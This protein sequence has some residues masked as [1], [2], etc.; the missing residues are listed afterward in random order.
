MRFFLRVSDLFMRW[1]APVTPEFLVCGLVPFFSFW[2]FFMAHFYLMP[3]LL[4][5]RS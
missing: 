1:L 5:F 3:W 4:E 2:F